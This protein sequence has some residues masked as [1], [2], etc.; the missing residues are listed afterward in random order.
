VNGTSFSQ[1]LSQFDQGRVRDVLIQGPE[2]HGT[3]TDGPGKKIWRGEREPSA[4][5]AANNYK[6]PHYR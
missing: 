1:L 2:I 5:S 6:D 4:F 3:F